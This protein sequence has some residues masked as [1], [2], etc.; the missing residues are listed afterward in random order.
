MHT[1][2]GVQR[3]R[4]LNSGHMQRYP[5]IAVLRSGD[6]AGAW[7]AVCVLFAVSNVYNGQRMGKLVTRPLL[8][9]SDLTVKNGAL[10]IHERSR[11]HVSNVARALEFTS[12]RSDKSCGCATYFTQK[13]SVAEQTGSCFH[14]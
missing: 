9:F 5:W 10:D 7:C 2:S 11:C 3:R 13:T 4:S 1:K 8:D 12:K 14:C 6:K